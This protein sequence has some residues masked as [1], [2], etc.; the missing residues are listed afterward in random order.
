MFLVLHVIAIAN[1]LNISIDAFGFCM[2]KWTHSFLFA[3]LQR[4]ST[5]MNGT[6]KST[7]KTKN[8]RSNTTSIY[9]QAEMMKQKATCERAAFLCIVQASHLAHLNYMGHRSE[10]GQGQK[11]MPKNCIYARNT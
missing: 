11:E 7:S 4:E 9:S 3:T 6:F 1:R 10:G 8:I 2:L 5:Q